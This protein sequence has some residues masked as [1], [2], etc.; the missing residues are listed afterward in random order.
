MIRFCLDQLLEF[1]PRDDY[2]KLLHLALLFQ[3]H[4]M[5]IHKTSKLQRHSTEL[6][7]WWSR[8][9]PN[10]LKIYLFRSRFHL[11]PRELAG[12]RDFNIFVVQIYLKASVPF[13]LHWMT[14][15]YW[16][17][18]QLTRQIRLWLRQRW[19]V[20]PAI[21]GTWVKHWY[22]WHSLIHECLMMLE[23]QC[24]QP[25]SEATNL[26]GGS[27]LM[28]SMSQECNAVVWFCYA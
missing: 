21:S 16:G 24:W 25:W 23:W 17:Y 14:W 3:V 5:I 19:K 8:F 26:N 9:T 1:Q 20:L 4:Q 28:K 6:D 27:K 2:K 22:V 18:S 15:S 12:L 13:W 7:G 11:T 10:C